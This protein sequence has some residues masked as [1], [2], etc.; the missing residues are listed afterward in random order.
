MK[1][2]KLIS[3][4]ILLVP[5]FALPCGLIGQKKAPDAK[6]EAIAKELK[7]AVKAGKLSEDQAWAK[8]KA[9]EGGHHGDA[10]KARGKEDLA[11]QLKAAVKAGKLTEKEAKAKWAAITKGRQGA[12]K[13]PVDM[14]AIAK[15]L[16]MMVK[17]GKLTEAEAKEKWV[18]LKEKY[19]GKD[20]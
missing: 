17:T 11:W 8:W 13:A 6:M 1:K 7:A 9:I 18:A 4:C 12:G 5:V 2:L 19:G 15:K 10:K 14:E 16:K 3:I 20:E